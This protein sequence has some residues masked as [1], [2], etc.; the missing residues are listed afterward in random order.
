MLSVSGPPLGPLIISMWV[1]ILVGGLDCILE[2]PFSRSG[3][4]G[5]GRAIVLRGGKRTFPFFPCRGRKRNEQLV[6]GMFKKWQVLGSDASERACG[7]WSRGER[8]GAILY[9]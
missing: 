7:L 5:S 3:G 8:R 1:G 9:A 2:F 4:P 6:V